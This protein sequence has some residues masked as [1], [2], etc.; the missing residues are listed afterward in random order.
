MRHL[1]VDYVTAIQKGQVVKL[2]DL[3]SRIFQF[4]PDET[5]MSMSGA[6]MHGMSRCVQCGTLEKL[7]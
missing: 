1:V 6:A 2:Q 5:G 3:Y 4:F 7:G